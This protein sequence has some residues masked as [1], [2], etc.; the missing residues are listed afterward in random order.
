MNEW[1]YELMVSRDRAELAERAATQL[2]EA[3]RAAVAQHGLL[4]LALSGGSTPRALHTLLASPPWRERVEWSRVQIFW[5]D[6]RCVSPD[7]ERSN[8]R[9]ARETLLDLVPIPAENIHRPRS[10]A[11]DREVAAAEYEATVRRIVP[12]GPGG[13]PS[14]DLI[15][16]GLG[17]DAHTASLLPGSRLVHET[18]HLVAV[19]DRER[20]GTIRLTF[21][22]PLLQHASML[23]FLATGPDKAPALREVLH[24]PAQPEK[25]PAQVVRRASGR[26][27]FLVD[28]AAASALPGSEMR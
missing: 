23:L 12:R 6:E 28:E 14:F 26:V 18:E 21:T 17:D 5:G 3:A 11:A 16:L 8:V 10:E 22:P 1:A 27:T 24:G 15:L 19:T 9:M 7:D 20:E 13:A 25:Y 4:T 2:V